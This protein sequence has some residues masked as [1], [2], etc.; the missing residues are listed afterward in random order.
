MLEASRA[1]CTQE[2]RDS[3]VQMAQVWLRLA[4]NK[5]RQF[6]RDSLRISRSC[7]GNSSRPRTTTK[8][9][10]RLSWRPHHDAGP[11]FG[12]H[13]CSW[14]RNIHEFPHDDT[15]HEKDSGVPSSLPSEGV[16]RTLPPG[17][18]HQTVTDEE[19]IEGLSFPVY[20]RISTM[21]LVPAQSHS[22]FDQ[23]GDDRS[24]RFAS[25]AATRC[26]NA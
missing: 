23:D 3:L 5:T 12:Q 24:S 21:I 22:L 19:M 9:M 13:P 17:E 20:R 14:R 1:R 26:R 7:S 16:D 15:Y 11:S 25:G 8:G 4:E 18:Y 2:E 10:G 6:D